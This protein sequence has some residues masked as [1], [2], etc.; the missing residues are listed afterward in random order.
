[1]QV[2]QHRDLRSRR[3]LNVPD[4]VRPDRRPR[5]RRASDFVDER[6][7]GS[8]PLAD[9][10]EVRVFLVLVVGV[11]ALDGGETLQEVA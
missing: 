7:M 6:A 1:V 8:N 4:E 3:I 11:E 9:G 2:E 10:I 5:G